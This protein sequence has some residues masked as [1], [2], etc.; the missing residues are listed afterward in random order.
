MLKKKQLIAA[1]TIFNAKINEVKI[2]IRSITNLV[3]TACLNAKI[4]E[5]INKI[6][7]ISNVGTTTALT[8]FE[9]KIPNVSN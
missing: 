3:T 5:I 7:N 2:E 6:P 8:A 1:N 4:N 9:N